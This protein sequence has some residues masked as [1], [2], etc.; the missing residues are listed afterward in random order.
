MLKKHSIL[1][2]ILLSIVLLL[3]ATLYYPGG[4]QQD[5]GSI[6][7]DWKN[8]YL[9]NLFSPKAV[10]GAANTAQ[11]WAV[12]G[13]LFLCSSFALFFIEFSKRIPTKGAAG[14]IKYFGFGGMLS[15][16]LT[17]T[18][19]HDIM[20]TLAATLM[21]VSMFYIT[22]F[23]FKSKR[24]FFKILSVVCLLI[25]YCCLY[26]YYTRSYLEILPIVQKLNLLVGIIWMICLHYF[27]T[28]N[29]FQQQKTLVR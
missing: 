8:N 3:I 14:I 9:S 4:S 21:L 15:A 18:P 16:F 25:Y 17:V 5:K 13:M 11:P 23:V 2:G 19:Y 29:D 24:V 6:G 1:I 20:I 10:N 27:T 7:Y 12:A 22:I 28:K 26:I